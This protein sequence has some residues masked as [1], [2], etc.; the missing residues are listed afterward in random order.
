MAEELQF[1]LRRNKPT[2][3]RATRQQGRIG[4]DAAIEESSQAASRE[5]SGAIGARMEA[6]ETES[7]IKEMPDGYREPTLTKFKDG[8]L[9]HKQARSVIGKVAAH[10]VG[11]LPESSASPLRSDLSSGKVT[12]GQAVAAALKLLADQ[13]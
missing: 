12:P 4:L 2:G 7:L 9:T 11:R 13:E 3:T 10:V 5:G 1:D 6:E 8:E